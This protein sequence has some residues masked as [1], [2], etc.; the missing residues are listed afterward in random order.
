MQKK[1]KNIDRDK[2]YN[3]INEN[4]IVHKNHENETYN[5]PFSVKNK[6]IYSAW[7][8]EKLSHYPIIIED[9][10]VKVNNLNRI[11]EAEKS[12]ILERIQKYNMAIYQLNNPDIAAFDLKTFAQTFGLSDLDKHFCH[13]KGGITAL[14]ISQKNNKGGFIPYSDR[15]LNWHTDGYYNPPEQKVYAVLLHC[16]T[17]ASEGGENW[18]MDHEMA[19]LR[20]RDENPA[21]IKALMHPEAMT[22][23]AHIEDGQEIRKQQAGPVFSTYNKGQNLHMRFSQR[24]KNIVWRNDAMTTEAVSALNHIL[25]DIRQDALH[26]KLQAGQGVLC[27]N[28]L[29]NRSAFKDNIEQPRLMYRGRF[30]EPVI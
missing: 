7:R 13:D 9:V 16:H 20:L 26:I 30:F 21:Y 5:T 18:F 2:T 25:N 27:N 28:V 4:V 23:P 11:T 14:K 8:S 6:D 10:L 3:D 12:D 1:L 19:Y 17:P 22:L 15:A 24:K 29:H